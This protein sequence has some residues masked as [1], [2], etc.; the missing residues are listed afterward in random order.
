M[1]ADQIQGLREIFNA[2]DRSHKGEISG[3]ELEI[4]IK[5]FNKELSHFE[6]D[7]L[8]NQVSTSTE[9]NDSVL[10]FQVTAS[11]ISVWQEAFSVLTAPLL[12][13]EFVNMMTRPLGCVD[14]NAE[15]KDV[16]EQ[17]DYDK[18][19]KVSVA[20]LDKSLQALGES[21]R[22]EE[23]RTCDHAAETFKL[24]E[25]HLGESDGG[26]SRCRWKWTY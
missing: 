14:P 11:P 16:Y 26:R 18:D 6:I 24:I 13:Q 20:D 15:L 25:E 23:A 7:D 10:D 2:V 5:S 22:L 8:V 21:F 12:P 17:L 3:S 1:R 4:V 19:G 9:G